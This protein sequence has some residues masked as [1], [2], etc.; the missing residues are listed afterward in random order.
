MRKRG[1]SLAGTRVAA[2]LIVGGLIGVA[3]LQP[4]GAHVNR[5]LKHL[6][7]HLNPVY[8]NEGQAA[9]GGLTGDF[10]DPLIAPNAV[11]SAEVKPNSLTDQDLAQSSVNSFQVQN[12]SL[13]QEDLG[14]N[15]VGANELRNFE[16]FTASTPAFGSPQTGGNGSYITRAVTVRCP[17]PNDE[18]ITGGAQ[19]NTNA[20]DRELFIVQSHWVDE[21][22]SEGPGW[23]VRGGIDED[24]NVILTAQVICMTG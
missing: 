2:L 6:R 12:D 11:G 18:V 23:R 15:S 17:N 10:P 22:V 19:W 1:R 14:Q 8:V 7:G 5:R 21:T 4:S 20:D 16:I 3:L 9:G 13:D 24:A